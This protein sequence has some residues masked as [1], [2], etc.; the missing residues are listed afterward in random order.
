MTTIS[1]PIIDAPSRPD[2]PPSPAA[3]PERARVYAAHAHGSSVP[4][5]RHLNLLG[6][7]HPEAYLVE[8]GELLDLDV[9]AEKELMPLFRSG[10]DE[11][12]ASWLNRRGLGVSAAA[13]QT[14]LVGSELRALS[15]AV[16]QSCN[17]GCTY[18]YAQQGGFGGQAKN[19]SLETATLAVDFLLRDV[20]R[21]EKV[22]LAFLGGEPLVNRPVLRSVTE[23]AR[24]L[25]DRRGVQINFSITTNG[26]L[27]EHD[28]AQFFEEHGFA[29][30]VSLDGTRQM[31][32]NLR[33]LKG[34]AGSYDRIILRLKPLLR[35]QRR[36]QVS[37]RVTVTPLNL[38]LPEILETFVGL[39]F[40]SV[41]FS[42]LLTSSSGSHELN[43]QGLT[44]MLEAMIECGLVFEQNVLRGR[45]YPFLNMVNALREL[46]ARTRRSY[47]CGAG[48]SYLGVSADGELS[49]CHRFVN[50]DA[51]AMGNLRAGIDRARQQTWMTSRHLQSQQPCQACW[52]RYLC[53]GGCHHEV[54]ARGRIAC[55]F[56]RGWLHYA[57]EA[58]GRLTR[59]APDWF[60]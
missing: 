11:A 52:A 1:L 21:G 45:R 33:P 31:H 56:I 27:L 15:L 28:D 36:M 10:D 53:S 25:A 57:L 34:G 3:A 5:S 60:A 35:L 26:T 20:K 37:A 2:V 58:Y 39:G 29:V 48:I 42:P 4:R 41:G 54:F 18:C 22:N 23:Y 13:H 8:R 16:A 49:A 7:T 14:P 38:E 32:D 40:H 43:G 12:I 6:G 59:L 55:D 46:R 44:R 19:M 9:S 47:P 24:R 51:A 17:L 30:T 50:D